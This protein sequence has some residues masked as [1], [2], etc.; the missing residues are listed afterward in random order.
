VVP[1]IDV[2]GTKLFFEVRPIRLTMQNW[3]SAWQYEIRIAE[4]AKKAF[5]YSIPS[6]RSPRLAFALPCFKSR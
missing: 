5:V 1:E 3:L 4:C 6:G 2:N